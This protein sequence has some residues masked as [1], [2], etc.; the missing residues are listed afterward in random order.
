MSKSLRMK[1]TT[2]ASA[3]VQRKKRNGNSEVELE[4]E[5]LENDEKVC[6]YVRLSMLG[7]SPLF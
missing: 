3:N 4:E 2:Q 6:L 7:K 5:A 1:S